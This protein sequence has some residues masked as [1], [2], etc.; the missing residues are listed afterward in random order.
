MATILA[1]P[2]NA[3]LVTM[4]NGEVVL[5]FGENR[6]RRVDVIP[7]TPLTAATVSPLCTAGA[8][9]AHCM[10]LEFGADGH[11]WPALAQEFLSADAPPKS[12]KG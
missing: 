9:V 12:G 6:F 5:T 11:C 7:S 4:K 3:S 10:A 8:Y 2:G 1:L